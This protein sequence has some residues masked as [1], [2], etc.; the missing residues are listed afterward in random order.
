[1]SFR[2]ELITLI[3]PDK[4]S[5]GSIPLKCTLPSGEEFIVPSNLY[6]IG[7]MNTADKSIAPTVL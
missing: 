3:E 6:L 5:H 7:T 1:M 4:R 2:I